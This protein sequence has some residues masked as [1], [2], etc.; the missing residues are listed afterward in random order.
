MNV[1]IKYELLKIL[2]FFLTIIKLITILLTMLVNVVSHN[3]SVTVTYLPHV[4]AHFE[5]TR[6]PVDVTRVA[7]VRATFFH[8]GRLQLIDAA[9]LHLEA[10]QVR[11][12]GS[13]A[14][15]NKIFGTKPIYMQVYIMVHSLYIVAGLCHLQ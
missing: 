15:K 4:V 3:D 10:G 14:N 8:S 7:I 12:L 5:D 2:I 6:L 11:R 13:T 9:T 1:L